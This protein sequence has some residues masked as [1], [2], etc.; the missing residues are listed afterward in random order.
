[1]HCAQL[2]GLIRREF[3]SGSIL[4]SE[5]RRMMEDVK[6]AVAQH[7][8][9]MLAPTQP[10]ASGSAPGPAGAA[11]AAT[12]AAAGDAGAPNA[13]AFAEGWMSGYLN[14]F[15]K[16]LS[17]T[18]WPAFPWFGVNL[19]GRQRFRLGVWALQANFHVPVKA[20]DDFQEQLQD[21]TEL[22]GI[23]FTAAQRRRDCSLRKGPG[24]F[25]LQLQL[26]LLCASSLF[27]CVWVET[28]CSDW[29]GPAL[30]LFGCA[31]MQ[32]KSLQL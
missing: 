19:V 24:P 20:D 27:V 21:L 2:F 22:A 4:F 17:D 8:Q 23:H 25:H 28:R 32:A 29:F 7:K 14:G 12:T 30:S 5:T 9:M 6:W 16:V 18:L 13:A 1:M 15:Q 11:A 31:R 3:D 26:Q 10:P